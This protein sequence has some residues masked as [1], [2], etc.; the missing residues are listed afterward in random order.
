MQINKA[1]FGEGRFFLFFIIQANGVYEMC[2]KELPCLCQTH[3]YSGPPLFNAATNR[4][5][6]CVAAV[7]VVSLLLLV[8][9]SVSFLT[10]RIDFLFKSQAVLKL[11][12]SSEWR[13][14]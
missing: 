3:K 12:R 2:V 1:L 10:L 4:L 5:H 9:Y 8:S 11:V 14:L 7:T 13:Q 6:A